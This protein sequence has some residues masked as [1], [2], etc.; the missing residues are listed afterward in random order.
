M[1]MSEFELKKA[2]REVVASEFVNIPYGESGIDYTFSERF[3]KKMKK[4]IRSQKKV[5]WRC[6]NTASRRVATVCIV[7]LLFF[8]AVC[9]V[10]AIRE[11]MTQILTNFYE[12]HIEYL[13]KGDTVDK[14]AYE[15]SL[16]KLP[17]GFV[18]TD[19]QESDAVI[20]TVYEN[21]TG[22]IIEFSQAITEDTPFFV[23]NE[24][25]RIYTGTL[26]DV[27]VEIYEH[28]ENKIAFWCKS[29]YLFNI[30][31]YG[32]I[33]MDMLKEMILSVE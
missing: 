33:D 3:N 24:H 28:K 6:I 21:D 20:I 19:K 8:T 2:F 11:P 26:D 29:G 30:A 4:L 14:I 10:R 23:D 9:N 22:D 5:Y 31:C 13:F 27:S 1:A 18:Q 17:D 32:N 15:Y 7:L 12:D 25:G 16:R